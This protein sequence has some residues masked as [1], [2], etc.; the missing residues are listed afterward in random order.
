[1]NSLSTF[2][3]AVGDLKWNSDSGTTRVAG[4]EE[5]R[6]AP[7]GPE[8]LLLRRVAGINEALACGGIYLH[9][10]ADPRKWWFA[11]GNTLREMLYYSQFGTKA[12]IAPE[13]SRPYD[14]VARRGWEGYYSY[15]QPT[16]A[17]PPRYRVGNQ[18]VFSGGDVYARYVLAQYF[19]S[20]AEV[21]AFA[22][23]TGADAGWGHAHAGSG[24]THSFMSTSVPMNAPFSSYLQAI[25]ASQLEAVPSSLRG[26]YE[27]AFDM[28]ISDYP[29]INLRP[30]V[31]ITTV[32]AG[33]T[34]VAPTR[35][36][37][38]VY[39]GTMG[40]PSPWNGNP[41]HL[42]YFGYFSTGFRDPDTLQY[43]RD[44]IY[45]EERVAP[46]PLWKWEF[47]NHT[48]EWSLEH[49]RVAK[50]R[51]MTRPGHCGSPKGQHKGVVLSAH[52]HPS[53]SMGL[54]V[55]EVSGLKVGLL[56]DGH[57][58]GRSLIGGTRYADEDANHSNLAELVVS[59]LD[60]ERDVS[61]G[62]YSNHNKSEVGDGDEA[63]VLAASDAVLLNGATGE[64]SIYQM[65]TL[66]S[67]LEKFSR[68]W[69]QLAKQVARN[70]S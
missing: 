57:L 35:W 45:R 17:T 62:P 43:P 36:K 69:D 38:L 25:R 22:V 33:V 40:A 30:T 1:M 68:Y 39:E 5:L 2:G 31:A 67:E 6:I 15:A 24:V 50:A 55:G 58:L 3:L 20:N 9:D 54:Q 8:G 34:E 28:A 14:L 32:W 56:R 21:A 18:N 37:P 66:P 12:V 46:D 11:C 60:Q 16:V 29:S 52:S 70:A 41:P 10:V 61:E 49:R 59:T 51:M 7:E 53:E 44:A 23:V 19:G 64:R 42:P 63:A 48:E 4:Y 27:Q 13:A 26:Y 65:G 47:G